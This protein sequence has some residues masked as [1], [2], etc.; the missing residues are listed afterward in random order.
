MVD[1][2]LV[3]DRVRCRSQ[4]LQNAKIAVVRGY[5]QSIKQAELSGDRC[6]IANTE[7][8]RVTLRQI[9]DPFESC[10]VTH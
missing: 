5:C 10:H 2:T 3:T 4:L 9:S 6:S 1:K 8:R 7:D